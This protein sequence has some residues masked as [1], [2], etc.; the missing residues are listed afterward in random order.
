MSTAGFLLLSIDSTKPVTPPQDGLQPRWLPEVDPAVS[1]PVA[2][3]VKWLQTSMRPGYSG[4]T[5]KNESTSEDGGDV[6]TS[7]HSLNNQQTMNIQQTMNNQQ[8][9]LNGG[10]EAAGSKWSDN[11]YRSPTV[12]QNRSTEL[13]SSM[14]I[15]SASDTSDDDIFLNDTYSKKYLFIMKAGSL[16]RHSDTILYLKHS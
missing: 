10:I 4:L 7:I 12:T 15:N 11:R 5:V 2:N 14:L 3:A 8:T 13:Y 9:L 6:P 16:L 1:K